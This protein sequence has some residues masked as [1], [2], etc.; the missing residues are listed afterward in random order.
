MESAALRGVSRRPVRPRYHDR[1]TPE[2]AGINPKSGKESSM[3][4]ITL[5]A[6][7]LA[8][9]TLAVTPAHGRSAERAQAAT[10]SDDAA[11]VH[12]LMKTSKGEIVL[13]LNPAKAPETVANFLRYVDKKF[14]DGTVFHRVIGNFMIQG[15]GF[16]A[17]MEK[18]QTDPPVENEW[19]NGLKNARGT[20]SMARLGGRPDS[21][22]S[23][24][25]INVVDNKFLDEPQR[26]GA[27]YAVFG[28]VVAG[29]DVVDKIKAVETKTA[30]AY[31]DVPVEPIVIEQ[32]T[33]IDKDDVKKK[34]GG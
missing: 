32:V 16:T 11:S 31:R 5:F 9:V 1:L 23:Q 19:Q 8:A 34:M 25:F 7:I 12:V 30:G 6:S 13:E 10:P 20:I 17:E 28:K 2:G 26:D 21:A 33:R 14:Y 15:G 29:M 18:K 3:N 22:T 24:F 4:R 27:A